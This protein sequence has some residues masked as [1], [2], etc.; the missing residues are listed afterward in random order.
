MLARRW[1][2]LLLHR[3]IALLMTLAKLWR[4]LHHLCWVV[5]EAL[6]RRRLIIRLL[7]PLRC[8]DGILSVG[9]GRTLH[10]LFLIIVVS[11]VV[12][13]HSVV[14]IRFKTRG[15]GMFVNRGKGSLAQN[16]SSYFKGTVFVNISCLFEVS[17]GI[18]GSGCHFLITMTKKD[19]VSVKHLFVFLHNLQFIFI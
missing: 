16:S 8:I 4:K 2:F 3:W 17:D 18:R 15:P 11:P 6:P 5:L 7:G 9:S 12:G 13:H 19:A 1:I 10:K 14:W